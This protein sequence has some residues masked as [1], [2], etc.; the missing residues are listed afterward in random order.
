MTWFR[1]LRSTIIPSSMDD[2]S[3]EEL[4]FHLEQRVEDYVA[5][6]MAP[7]EARRQAVRRLGNLTVA[8]EQTRDVDTLRW[9]DD[10][11]QDLRY[12]ARLLR[13]NAL[14]ALTAAMSLAIGIG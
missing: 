8:R 7:D 10:L 2:E 9:L 5:L 11:L 1:R 12:A 4:R 6:G 13:R 3:A 14:F